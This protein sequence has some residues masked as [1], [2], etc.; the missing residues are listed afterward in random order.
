MSRLLVAATLAWAVAAT[1]APAPKLMLLF[2][3]DNG[4]QVAPCG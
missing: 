2:T 4:A 3:G 1:A